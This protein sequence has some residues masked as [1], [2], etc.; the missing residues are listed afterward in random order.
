MSL[1]KIVIF[2]CSSLTIWTL[3]NPPKNPVVCVKWGSDC[4]LNS[5]F[6]Q[7]ENIFSFPHPKKGKKKSA[8]SCLF[9]HCLFHQSFVF[10]ITLADFFSEVQTTR[11]STNFIIYNEVINCILQRWQ[12]V[13]ITKYLFS[14]LTSIMPWWHWTSIDK[15]MWP[16]FLAQE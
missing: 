16:Q 7:L 13:V 15:S 2:L 8:M 14:L 5:L 4:D 11:W 1:V 3:T 12:D 10:V 6:T 9:S